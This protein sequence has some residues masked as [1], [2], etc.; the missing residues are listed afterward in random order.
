MQFFLNFFFFQGLQKWV[1]KK[2]L[3][4]ATTYRRLNALFFSITTLQCRGQYDIQNNKAIKHTVVQQ[5]TM[6]T[7]RHYTALDDTYLHSMTLHY[8]ALACAYWEYTGHYALQ[9]SAALH[10]GTTGRIITP[11]CTAH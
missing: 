5:T 9:A 6:L 10:Y 1:E 3:D 4:A 8:G 11:N 2:F 7:S